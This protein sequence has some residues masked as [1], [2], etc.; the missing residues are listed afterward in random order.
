MTN[1][2]AE[3]CPFPHGTTYRKTGDTGHAANPSAPAI[4][5]DGHVWHL[6]TYSAVRQVLRAGQ[7]TRQAILNNESPFPAGMRQP[8]IFQDG[9]LHV[10]QRTAIARFFTPKTVHAA[11]QTLMD[12]LSDKLVGEFVRQGEADLS[13]LS[14][15]LAT[16]VAAQIVG[17]TNS[18]RPGMGHRIDAMLVARPEPKT[19]AGGL[20]T[21][22]QNHARLLGFYLLDVRPAILS[23]RHAPRED[24][25]SHL[26]GM[27][28]NDLEILVEC[29]TYGS[30]GMVTTREFICVAAWHLL[31]N[32]AL[33]LEYLGADEGAR[34]RILHELLRLEPV[35]SH[36]Y[37]RAVTD[38]TLEHG[39]ETYLIPAGAMMNLD[40]RAANTDAAAV[41]TEPLAACPQR[42][43][44]PGVQPQALSFGDGA[45]RCPGAF[46]AIQESD[47]FLQ[48]LL[49]LPLRIETPPRLDWNPRL[50][51]YEVR[52][53]RVA[54]RNR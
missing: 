4:E 30:A 16:Q 42:E 17:L 10:K 45:H 28:Y 21:T 5:F 29:A 39:G 54:L 14:M 34:H 8:V 48:R 25:I 38:M 15:E 47:V 50:E 19:R 37:R 23:R 41:G 53:F 43:L 36:L 51:S 7:D 33:R 35:A 40:I 27:D 31:E 52:D 1:T 46:V 3:H 9:P 20:L 22:L 32:D 18:W 26:I 44:A 49:A 24:V 6:R 2:S 11:Y 12:D 13:V